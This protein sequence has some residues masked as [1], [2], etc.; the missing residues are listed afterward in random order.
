MSSVILSQTKVETQNFASHKQGCAINR[1][2]TC[3]SMLRFLLVRRKILRLYKADAVT[4]Y[5]KQ[6]APGNLRASSHCA[7]RHSLH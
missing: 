6:A 7:R 5:K 4:F 2:E 1:C 3:L